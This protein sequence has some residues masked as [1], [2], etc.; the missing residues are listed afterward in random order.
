MVDSGKI[1]IIILMSLIFFTLAMYLIIRDR[2]SHFKN[3]WE[4]YRCR[5]WVIPIAKVINPCVDPIKNANQCR[6]ELMMSVVNKA[7]G[8]LTG[9]FDSITGSIA[10]LLSAANLQAMFSGGSSNFLLDMV[11][12]FLEKLGGVGDVI[13]FM[14]IKI[15]A[16]LNK[17]LGII[18]VTYNIIIGIGMSLVW[19]WEVPRYLLVMFVAITLIIALLTC[20]W[21]PLFC[22]F[23]IGLASSIGVVHLYCFDA[24]TRIVMEDGSLCR[25]SEIR[26]G[27]RVKNGGE[28]YE[29]L[30]L[31][32]SR[33]PLYS[34]R[35]VLVSGSHIVWHQSSHSWRPVKYCPEAE[36][37][38]IY[39]DI[40]Y[41]L[42]TRNHSLIA[43]GED[44]SG[45][46]RVRGLLCRDY[47]GIDWEMDSRPDFVDPSTRV[48]TEIRGPHQWKPISRV[49][50]GD[51]I[52]N[53]ESNKQQVTAKIQSVEG[54][55][56]ITSDHHIVLE[57]GVIDDFYEGGDDVSESYTDRLIVEIL[58]LEMD[59]TRGCGLSS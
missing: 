56:L 50:I 21:L 14:L 6:K 51:W 41:C 59:R 58:N 33:E 44:N 57:N 13:R 4:Q 18:Q 12:Q 49:E 48:R 29:L 9:V 5:P 38:N 35:G 10:G 36:A 34:Y 24:T 53:R 27:D 19:I 28:V 42:S 2:L 3:N 39:R 46:N 25:I 23:M 45:D 47:H 17:F 55:Q 1:K 30:Q 16:I 7:T 52:V 22:K 8:P 37:T 26:L 43:V 32:G 15:R 20:W 11:N 54:C 40:I 31:D